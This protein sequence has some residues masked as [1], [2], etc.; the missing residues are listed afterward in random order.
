M[1]LSINYEEYEAIIEVL[2]FDIN[3]LEKLKEKDDNPKIQR[4]IDKLKRLK[5]KIQKNF[6]N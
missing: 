3:E 6:N 4:R 1:D 5:E 2:D